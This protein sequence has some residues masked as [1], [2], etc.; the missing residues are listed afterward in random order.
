MFNNPES[1]CEVMLSFISLWQITDLD[2]GRKTLA[3]KPH[4]A[5][6]CVLTAPI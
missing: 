4:A 6:N 2:V 1:F 5:S 3:L